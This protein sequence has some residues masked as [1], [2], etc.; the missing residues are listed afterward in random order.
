MGPMQLSPLRLAVPAEA[1]ASQAAALQAM[2]QPP[3]QVC[4]PAQRAEM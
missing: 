3:A 2:D 4:A 1:L